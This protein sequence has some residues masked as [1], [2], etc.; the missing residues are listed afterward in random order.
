MSILVTRVAGFIGFHTAS[1][2][3]KRGERVIGL[4]NLDDY[5]DTRLKEARLAEPRGSSGFVFAKPDI[6]ARDGIFAL[7]AAN[8]RKPLFVSQF[9][10][11][12]HG[13]HVRGSAAGRAAARRHLR[14]LVVGLRRQPQKAL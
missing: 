1:A 2:L 10:H 11:D 14:I 6:A 9:E 3:L 7:V 8:K 12:G 4:D 13:G 5:Y